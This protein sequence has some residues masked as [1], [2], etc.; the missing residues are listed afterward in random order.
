VKLSVSLSEADVAFLDVY[1]EEHEV[2]SRSAVVQR[3]VALLRANELAGAYV[4]AWEEWS[5]HDGTAW[6]VTAQ[7]GVVDEAG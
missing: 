6:D 3:A 7:D 2:E 1:A 4:A 5:A